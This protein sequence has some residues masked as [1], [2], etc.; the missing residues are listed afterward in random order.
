MSHQLAALEREVGIRLLEP[1]GR[2]VR[3]TAAALVL[4]EHT[5]KVLRQLEEAQ[6]EVAAL[7][8]GAVRGVVR[9]AAFQTVAHTVLPPAVRL[10][11]A[12]HPDLT[13]RI[14]HVSAETA[15]PALL[16]PRLQPRAGRGLPRPP[17]DP[18][19]PRAARFISVSAT[20]C[21]Y[22]PLDHATASPPVGVTQKSTWR[23]PSR[24]RDSCSPS[25]TR[26]NASYCRVA[27][28]RV[29]AFCC[30]FGEVSIPPD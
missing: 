13:L 6:A 1:V 14:T 21:A 17:G 22:G 29:W 18:G 10:L 8:G 7:R 11:A 19:N 24:A 27:S 23:A 28:A 3:L 4:V 5:E 16:A 15:L 26:P 9:V 25:S 20:S 30:C 2:S 12:R